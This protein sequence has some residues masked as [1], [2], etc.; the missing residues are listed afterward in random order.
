MVIAL[1]SDHTFIICAVGGLQGVL[2]IVNGL[3]PATID[4]D[5]SGSRPRPLAGGGTTSCHDPQI[6]STLTFQN[7]ATLNA[8]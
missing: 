7:I 2:G 6:L 3:R 5:T 8:T 4:I 1:I